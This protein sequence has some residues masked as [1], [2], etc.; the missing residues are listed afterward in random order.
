MAQLKLQK[1]Q[2]T[3]YTQAANFRDE[4]D[5]K[6]P[7]EYWLNLAYDYSDIVASKIYLLLPKG[8]RVL[9]CL[10]EIEAT[11]T[12]ITAI[13]VGDGDDTDGWIPDAWAAGATGEF[14][15]TPYNAAYVNGKWYR[16]LDTID[17]TFEGIATAG[18]GIVAAKIW[19]YVEAA[20]A[21]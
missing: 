15:L 9:Q 13:Y 10:H 21:E 8:A 11:L 16:T 20:A 5:G 4:D 18:S 1:G 2:Y 14:N 6:F 7:F 17:V 19:S 12:G 3:Q